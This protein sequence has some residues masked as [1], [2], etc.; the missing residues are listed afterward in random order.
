[1]PPTYKRKRR[2]KILDPDNQGLDL[3]K[4]TVKQENYIKGLLEGKTKR[5]AYIEAYDASGM[6]DGAIAVESSRLSRNSKIA[7]YLRTLQRIGLEESQV[8]REN[9]LAEMARLREL[10]VENQQ[11]SAGVQAEHYRGRVAGLYNDKL[12]LQVGPSNEMLLAQIS[13]L[14]GS[15]LA[16]ALAGAMGIESPEE[17]TLNRPP[18]LEITKE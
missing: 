10:A 3:P 15:E 17:E 11:I 2:E 1:M 9:H 4:L 7:L 14:L 6:S 12:S 13:A 8:T 18:L 16:G 5:Q